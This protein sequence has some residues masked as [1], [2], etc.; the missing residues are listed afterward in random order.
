MRVTTIALLVAGSL[1]SA[2]AMAATDSERI[3]Q[4]EQQLAAVK[5]RQDGSSWT[6]KF[7]INGFASVAAGMANNDAD[8]MGYKNELNWEPDSIFG[9]QGTFTPVDKL[10]ATVQ[11]TTSGSND[12]DVKA[13]WAYLAYTFDNGSKI[14]GGKLRVPFYMYSD[15]LEVGYAYPFVRPSVDVYNLVAISSYTGADA[16]IPVAV[17][18]GTLTFQP[19]LGESSNDLNGASFKTKNLV[20][21]VA[22][23]D[24]N[25]VILRGVYSQTK[26]E[27]DA[28]ALSFMDGKTGRFIG[29]GASYDPGDWFV[30]SELGR[31][32]LDGSFPDNDAAYIAGGVRIN[33]VT[34]YV[35]VGTTKSKDDDERTNATLK[36]LGY[37][38]ASDTKRNSYSVG[39]RWDFMPQVDLKFDTTWLDNFGDTTG[40]LPGNSS[41]LGNTGVQINNGS[42][43]STVLYTLSVDA[44]F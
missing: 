19:F 43:D 6:E 26:V 25:S 41:A 35:M 44:V 21:L 18:E 38:S 36:A 17:G 40:G 2:S 5:A 30:V 23:Y 22:Q 28:A 11:L 7:K 34:P 9:I 27:S 4:L 12:W 42:Y 8:F 39:V 14:R 31:R 37:R 24:I 16:L 3:S 32:E 33:S 1:A 13:E 10:E 20:G 15:Y 29:V